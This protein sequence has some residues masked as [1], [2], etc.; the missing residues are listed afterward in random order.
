MVNCGLK[1]NVEKE[2]LSI[3]L[4]RRIIL[5]IHLVFIYNIPL[6]EFYNI[7]DITNNITMAIDIFQTL[8]V[9]EALENFIYKIRP[10]EEL[11]D[12]VDIVYKIKDQSVLIFEQRPHL[13]KANEKIESAIAK[14]TYIK[15]KNHWKVFW[16]K[17]DLKWHSYIPCPKVDTIK[18]FVDLVDEDKNSC[19]WG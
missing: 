6:I 17:S 11:R 5:T 1:A 13:E 14:T 12:Q 3:L 15:A 2:V 10:P 7:A 19:F 8:D 9:I 16:M 4:F 18:E